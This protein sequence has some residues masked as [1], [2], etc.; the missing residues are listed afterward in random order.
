MLYVSGFRLLV[1][2]GNI[3]L[4]ENP[5]E[6]LLVSAGIIDSEIAHSS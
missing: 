5:N 3:D 1:S 6:H 2:A 4:T